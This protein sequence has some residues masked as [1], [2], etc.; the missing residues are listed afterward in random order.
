MSVGRS[1]YS[2]VLGMLASLYVELVEAVFSK[3]TEFVQL[4]LNGFSF[5]LTILTNEWW[6]T[7][8]FDE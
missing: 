3:F 2:R 7:V 4:A 5:C 6:Q 8:A 1:S